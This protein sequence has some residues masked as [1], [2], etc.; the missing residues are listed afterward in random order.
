MAGKIFIN[1]RRGDDPGHTGRLF[2]RLQDVFAPGQLFLDVDNIAPGLDFVRV[3]N[4]RVAE[5]DIVL[6]VIG[7]NWLDARDAKGA[8]RLDD[9]DDFVRV[10]ITSALA[11]DKRVIPVL[12]GDAQ[13]PRPE[14][15]PEALR[16]LARRNAVRLTYERFRT[17]MAGLIKALQQA[18]NEIGA[19]HRAEDKAQ[20]RAEAGSTSRRTAVIFSAAFAAVLISGAGLYWFNGRSAPSPAPQSAKPAASTQA[21]AVAPPPA[22]APAVAAPSAAA[23]AYNAPVYSPPPSN[24]QAYKPSYQSGEVKKVKRDA[25]QGNLNLRAG[26]GQDQKALARIPA[27]ST[28]VVMSGECQPPDDGSSDYPYCNVQWNGLRGWVSSN[29]LE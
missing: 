6:A 24:Q 12:V 11:Q 20:R 1:Y 27:G 16:P 29:G 22:S 13:M 3:L 9:P 21:T 2:D 19:K 15:L 17:D 23:P 5:C 7:K 4:D 18:L 28:N 25:S 14:E 26:P 10:E 8:R